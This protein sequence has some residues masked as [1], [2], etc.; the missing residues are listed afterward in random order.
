MPRVCV[1]VKNQFALYGHGMLQQ[2]VIIG[3]VS[4]QIWHFVPTFKVAFR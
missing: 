2:G 1:C 4:H 3:R